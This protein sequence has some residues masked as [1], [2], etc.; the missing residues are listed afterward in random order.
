MRLAPSALL[1][2]L[3]SG[4][5][6]QIDGLDFDR[7][8]SDESYVHL[9]D[10]PGCIPPAVDEGRVQTHQGGGVLLKN[11]CLEQVRS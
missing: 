2:L 10:E 4:I 11:V 3:A 7:T 8:F 6:C 5:A 1:A 9:R